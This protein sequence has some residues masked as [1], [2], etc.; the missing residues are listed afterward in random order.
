MIVFFIKHIG[1]VVSRGHLIDCVWRS[2]QGVTSRTVDTHVSRLRKKLD[3]DR[4]HGWELSA[5]YQLGYQLDRTDSK[6]KR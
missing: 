6:T 4:A 1:R 2:A 5:I 3:L